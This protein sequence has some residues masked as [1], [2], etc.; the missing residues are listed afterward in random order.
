[1][2]LLDLK[3]VELHR[4][5]SAEHVDQHLQLALLRVDL[6]DLAVEVGER[7]VDHA[8]RLAD[9]EL[10]ANL[11]RLLLHLLLDGANLFLLQR[12]RAVR[13]THEARDAGRVAN[14]EPRLVGHH[15]AHEDVAG[16]IRFC[17]WR[18]LPSLISISSSIGT[19][20][21]RILSCMSMDS[22]LFSRFFLTFSSWP[23]YAWTTY[24]CASVSGPLVVAL[25]ST[26]ISAARRASAAGS[27]R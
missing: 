11:R 17:T 15:H 2:D 10:D 3:K 13:G 8:H 6:I 24:H 5:L 20:T 7:S 19:S 4:R 18:R 16:K 12:H 23:E 14:D 21:C 9:L 1:V 22:I 27:Q 25:F 26:A